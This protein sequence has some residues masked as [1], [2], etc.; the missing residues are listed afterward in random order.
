[1]SGDFQRTMARWLEAARSVGF[2]FLLV[3]GS[4]AFGLAIAWPLWLFATSQSKLFTVFVVCL[5]GGGFIALVARAI[6]RRQR[7]RRDPG[8]PLRSL[9]SV[10]LTLMLVVIAPAGAYLS[11]VLL[12]RG[13]L[14]LALPAVLIWAGLLWFLGLLRRKTKAR[15]DG[16]QPAENRGE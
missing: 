15:K 9:L 11:A 4:G 1:M 7:S 12:Y 3:L 6:V 5:A 14:V 16:A 8:R 2:F 10:L 13:L